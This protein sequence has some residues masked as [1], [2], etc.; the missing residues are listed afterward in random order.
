MLNN[1]TIWVKYVEYFNQKF[2][3]LDGKN[4]PYLLG[5]IWTSPTTVYKPAK[6][7][8]ANKILTL[9]K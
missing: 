9:L 7:F 5:N 2:V 8:L 3:D 6:G 1:S 4:D